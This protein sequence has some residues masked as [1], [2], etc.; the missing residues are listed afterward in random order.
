[1]QI[2]ALHIYRWSPEKSLLLSSHYDLSKVGYFK[3]KYVQEGIVFSSRTV[4]SRTAK[5]QRQSVKIEGDVGKCHSYVA[6]TGLA[7]TVITDNEYPNRVAF[8]FMSEALKTFESKYG[9]SWNS[10]SATEDTEL[11][12]HEADDIMAK[13]QNPAET[14]K[15]TKIENELN[16]VRDIVL[17]TMDDILKRGETLDSLLQKSEDLSQVSHQFYRTAK[18]TNQCCSVGG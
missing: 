4:V 9:Q 14:D 10:A 13:F 15:I 6:P 1:M 16:D 3:R 7:A 2:V 11:G 5:G 12:F 18:K 8:Q 17:K